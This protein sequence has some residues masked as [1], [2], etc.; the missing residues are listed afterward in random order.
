MKKHNMEKTMTQIPRPEQ[1][2]QCQGQ[3]R[4][5]APIPEQDQ[6][7]IGNQ[8]QSNDSMPDQSNT[9]YPQNNTCSRS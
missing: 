1:W 8:N 6:S 7:N 4:F 2:Y 3:N 9:C 5:W